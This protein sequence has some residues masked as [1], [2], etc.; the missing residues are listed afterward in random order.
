MQVWTLVSI[1]PGPTSSRALTGPSSTGSRL[2]IEQQQNQERQKGQRCMGARRW[3]ALAKLPPHT[4]PL[5]LLV[6]LLLP[7]GFF[8]FYYIFF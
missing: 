7:L 1:V 2:W 6:P 3:M 5:P 4:S 8:S